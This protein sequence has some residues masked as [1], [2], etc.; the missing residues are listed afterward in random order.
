MS[1]NASEPPVAI[2]TVLWKSSAELLEESVLEMV[3]LESN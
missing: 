2:K 3:E 1:M